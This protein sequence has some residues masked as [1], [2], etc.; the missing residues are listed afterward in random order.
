VRGQVPA[1]RLTDQDGKPFGSD[2][3][4]GRAWVANFIFTRCPDIC[5]RFTEKMGE[6]QA[7]TR[8]L[9]PGLTLVSFSV[10]PAYDTPEVLRAYAAAH[11][12]EPARWRFV[13]GSLADVKAAVEQGMKV[14]MEAKGDKDGVPV[15]GH[16]SHFVLV[17]AQGRIRGYY[18]MNDADAV[19][20]V[21]KDARRLV[22]K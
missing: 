9:A 3:L 7:Q 8:A 15:I 20:R 21:V 12:A 13:T 1:F 22:G 10:D 6:I 19:A 17:D 14:D 16:G 5:P 4:A 18:D 2:E 11:G